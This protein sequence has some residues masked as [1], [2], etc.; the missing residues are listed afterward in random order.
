MS[1]VTPP[2]QSSDLISHSSPCEEQFKKH[3]NENNAYRKCGVNVDEGLKVQVQEWFWQDSR[4]VP[5][6]P[7]LI[8]IDFREQSTCCLTWTVILFELAY[9]VSDS[10]EWNLN[11]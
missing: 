9:T 4:T 5:R 6:V 8:S 11:T 3:Y 2:S 10:A 1:L 7:L